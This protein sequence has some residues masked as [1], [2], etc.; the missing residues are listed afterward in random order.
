MNQT[1]WDLNATSDLFTMQI[2]I[3]FSIPYLKDTYYICDPWATMNLMI[4]KIYMISVSLRNLV[5]F[6]VLY[7]LSDL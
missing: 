6:F 2:V 4:F 3:M 1:I 7:I 5:T